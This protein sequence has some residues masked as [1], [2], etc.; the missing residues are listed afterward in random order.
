MNRNEYI[1]YGSPE[2]EPDYKRKSQHVV[3]TI[4]W[5]GTMLV[6]FC[7]YVMALVPLTRPT[8]AGPTPMEPTIQRLTPA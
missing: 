1:M 5:A 7:Y 2:Y 4:L 6:F 3:P 8:L